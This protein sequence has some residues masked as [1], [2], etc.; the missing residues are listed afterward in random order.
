MAPSS[1]LQQRR[2]IAK[3]C[4]YCRGR[5]IRCDTRR[6][7]C[8]ACLSHSRPCEYR[9]SAPRQRPTF[10]EIDALRQ[11]KSALEQF[12]LKLKFANGEERA[13]LLDSASTELGNLQLPE[14]SHEQ[15]NLQKPKDISVS[16]PPSQSILDDDASSDEDPDVGHFI[17]IDEAGRCDNFGPSSALRYPRNRDQACLRPLSDSC[18]SFNQARDSLIANAALQRQQ[19]HSLSK[20]PNIEGVPV[21]VGIHLLN[22]HWARQHHTFLL[23]Y[24]PAIM[25]D[26]VHGGPNC[27]PFLLNAIFACSSKFSNMTEIRSDPTDASTAGHQFFRNCDKLLESQGFLTRPTLPTIIGLLLLGSSHVARGE[28]SKGWLYTGYALRMVYDLGLHLEPKETHQSPEDVE[29]RRRVFWGAFICDKVQSLYLGRPVAI[30][31]RDFHVSHEF[32][33]LLEEEE[34]YIPIII[35]SHSPPPMSRIAPHIPIL[36]VSTFRQLCLLSR[37]MTKIISTF[38]VVGARSSNARGSLERVDNAL[39]SWKKKL[40]QELVFDPV[41]EQS[42]TSRCLAPNGLNLHCMYH[43]LVILLH[44]PF[45][46]DDQLRSAD[47]TAQSWNRCTNAAYNITNFALAYKNAY[48]LE[49]APYILSYTIYVACTIHV[50]NVTAEGKNR[51]VHSALLMSSLS[52]LD[53]LCSANPGVAR[54]AA[55]IRR[56]IASNRL[57]LV[58]DDSNLSDQSS[59]SLDLNSILNTFPVPSVATDEYLGMEMQPFEDWPSALD[60]DTLADPLFGIMGESVPFDVGNTLLSASLD[61]WNGE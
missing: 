19:E 17:S 8:S 18:F 30:N 6:P 7:S 14:P 58:M 36:S 21:H 41:A 48:S 56:L 55:I 15:E 5:K 25:R 33:D 12:I 51:R 28:A 54:P 20:L 47:T 53:D 3:A 59:A 27:T 39:Q 35:H 16:H 45:I 22:V 42:N 26:L 2:T 52:C 32:M 13:S 37:I 24:R 49:A 40:P 10:A 50:R 44:R 38:Y 1:S 29:I 34:P 46:T 31:L 23:T 61:D 43:S 9:L 11:Q 4:L 57:D 60:F